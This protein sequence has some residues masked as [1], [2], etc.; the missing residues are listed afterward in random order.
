MLSAKIML[1]SQNFN[2][3]MGAKV[4]LIIPSRRFGSGQCLAVR[5]PYQAILLQ[6]YWC[7]WFCRRDL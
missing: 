1:N 2:Y 6:Q 5:V 4:R 7:C 3:W